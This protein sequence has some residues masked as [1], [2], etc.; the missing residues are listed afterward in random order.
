MTQTCP[1]DT[2]ARNRP[3]CVNAAS[4]S[5]LVPVS[6]YNF[7]QNDP[8]RLGLDPVMQQEILAF[9]PPPNDFS[10]GDGLNTAGYRWNSPSDRPSTA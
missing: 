5:P 8:R 9:L 3:G 4:G 6:S 10:V 1:G 2:V 7:A